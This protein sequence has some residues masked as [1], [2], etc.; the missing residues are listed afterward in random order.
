MSFQIVRK[1][2]TPNEISSP[3]IRY[4]PETDSY[5]QTFDGGATW[6]D[7]PSLDPRTA[8]GYRMPPLETDDPRC[9]AAANMVAALR[10]M[11]NVLATNANRV[12]LLTYMF[13]VFFAIVPYG[14]IVDVILAV[15]DGLIIVGITP[16]VEAMTED[17]YD[18]FLCIFYCNIDADGQMSQGQLSDIYTAVAAQFDS[19]IQGGFGTLS[20]GLGPNGWSNAGATGTETGD[21]SGCECGWCRVLDFTMSDYGF[22]AYEGFGTYVPGVGWQTTQLE[23]AYTEL[24]YL[25]G[26]SITNITH[27]GL[28]VE[29]DVPPSGGYDAIIGFGTTDGVTFPGISNWTPIDT[30]NPN[31]YSYEPMDPFDLYSFYFN[32]NAGN[33]SHP[34]FNTATVKSLLLRGTGDPPDIGEEC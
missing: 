13:G 5:Q 2:L 34:T 19:T 10:Q 16:F 7:A 6:V 9:D 12:Q 3:N 22:V 32:P 31:T 33:D 24:V 20:G 27:L 18:Q 21:C 8:P 25:T 29:Y 11:V 17:V 23:H 14:W 1:K 30:P 15:I 28:T 26:L 4:V